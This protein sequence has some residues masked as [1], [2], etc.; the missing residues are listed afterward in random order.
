MPV[1]SCVTATG[2]ILGAASV[3]VAAE[4]DVQVR[5]RGTVCMPD[6]Q[7]GRLMTL[8]LLNLIVEHGIGV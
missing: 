5:S 7:R 4:A 1:V 8:A 3:A 6:P 2:V